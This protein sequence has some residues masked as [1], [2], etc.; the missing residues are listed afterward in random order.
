MQRDKDS[1]KPDNAEEPFLR[2]VRSVFLFIHAYYPEFSAVMEKFQVNYSQYA[3]LLTLYMFGT[4]SEGEMAQMINVNPSTMS[5]MVYALEKRG[6]L[7]CRRDP[8]DRRRVVITLTPRGRRN[9]EEM[10]RQPAKVLVRVAA[11]LDKSGRDALY[12]LVENINHTLQVLTELKEKGGPSNASF[13]PEV[14]ARD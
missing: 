4:L 11:S 8:E 2:L 1:G 9:V 14:R 12:R 6:W 10:M 7:K 13:W 3:S 5:R